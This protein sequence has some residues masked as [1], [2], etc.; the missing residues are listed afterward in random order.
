MAEKETNKEQYFDFF[1]D[2]EAVLSHISSDNCI[3]GLLDAIFPQTGSMENAFVDYLSK[4]SFPPEVQNAGKV[5]AALSDDKDNL[6]YFLARLSGVLTRAIDPE[7][8]KDLLIRLNRALF[9]QM[10]GISVKKCLGE[11][12]AKRQIND[13]VFF[14]VLPADINSYQ[15]DAH[16]E[17]LLSF[18]TNAQKYSFKCTPDLQ[19]Y[20]H[21]IHSRNKS[22]KTKKKNIRRVEK[23]AKRIIQLYG[24]KREGSMFNNSRHLVP[25]Q[26]ADGIIKLCINTK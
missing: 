1:S 25:K 26:F 6:R 11:G 2:V 16:F 8:K 10:Y 18:N 7:K 13:I 15:K 9:W 23:R 5:V 19:Y 3:D 20:L 22:P 17:I 24:L 21:P 12:Q 14:N 4:Y